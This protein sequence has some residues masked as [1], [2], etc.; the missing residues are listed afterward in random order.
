M[1]HKYF[2]VIYEDDMN[3]VLRKADVIATYD[4]VREDNEGKYSN[5][6]IYHLG[7]DF[8]LLKALR[9]ARI[10]LEYTND[11][12]DGYYINSGKL[13]DKNVKVDLAAFIKEELQ[14]SKAFSKAMALR[15]KLADINGERGIVDYKSDIPIPL[16]GFKSK[17]AYDKNVDLVL[18]FRERVVKTSDSR[19]PIIVYLHDEKSLGMN[20]ISQMPE[21]GY[22]LDA[23][24]KSKKEHIAIVP[25]AL[26][27]FG[28]RIDSGVKANA[29]TKLLDEILDYAIAKLGGDKNKIYIVGTGIGAVGAIRVLTLYPKRYAGAIFAFGIEGMDDTSHLKDISIEAVA[30]ENDEKYLQEDFEDFVEEAKENGIDVYYT[31]FANADRKIYKNYYKE[32]GFVSRLFKEEQAEESVQSDSIEDQD[33]SDTVIDSESVSEK[34]NGNNEYS[35]E[36]AESGI[37]AENVEVSEADNVS[38][39]ESKTNAD[40]ISDDVQV[41]AQASEILINEE[42]EVVDDNANEE[43][44]NEGSNE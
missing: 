21:A 6:V 17:I 37:V 3:D 7:F 20:N 18:P 34:D 10:D 5:T 32:G 28:R 23:L 33:K 11:D 14:R 44:Q 9:D 8:H 13:T 31:V 1:E 12:G 27:P 36:E 19:L 30:A 26:V 41:D 35:I 24:K 25:H 16:I 40:V 42:K 2:A 22:M 29:L 39:E 4:A 43:M 38:I 15:D